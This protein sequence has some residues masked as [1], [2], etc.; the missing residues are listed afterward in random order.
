VLELPF[1]LCVARNSYSNNSVMK[2]T[3]GVASSLNK[4]KI[5]TLSRLVI[6]VLLVANLLYSFYDVFRFFCIDAFYGIFRRSIKCH[7]V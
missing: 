1:D 4:I 7:T 2:F 6:A 3:I 5:S